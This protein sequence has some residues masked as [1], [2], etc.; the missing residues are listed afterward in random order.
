MCSARRWARARQR[1]VQIVEAGGLASDTS[2]SAGA[3]EFVGF[4]GTA[5]GATI[6]WTVE[7]ANGSVATGAIAFAGGGILKLDD[8]QR[9]SGTVAGFA[10]P[11]AIDLVD[12]G[13]GAGTTLAFAEAAGNTSG[14]LSVTSGTHTANLLLLGQYVAGQFNLGADGNGGTVVTDPPLASSAEMAASVSVSQ[15]HAQ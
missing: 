7:L 15:P 6:A 10:L 3:V 2:V 9:F 13:F 14:T 12:I 11:D 8:S 1:T 4:G 5:A